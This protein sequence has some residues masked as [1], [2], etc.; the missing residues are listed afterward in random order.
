M[1]PRCYVYIIIFYYYRQ[2]STSQQ[3]VTS[4][5]I[6]DSTSINRSTQICQK[7]DAN[8]IARPGI[9]S[10]LAY[11]DFQDFVTRSLAFADKSELIHTLMENHTTGNF[12]VITSPP[13]WGKSINLSM[14]KYF[15]GIPLETYYSRTI[16]I[17]NSFTYNYFKN[18]IVKSKESIPDTEISPKPLISKY[19]ETITKYLG[20]FP[21]IQFIPP[22]ISG[23][24]T[25]GDLQFHIKN[26]YSDF[27]NLKK[28]YFPNHISDEERVQLLQEFERYRRTGKPVKYSLSFLAKLVS[29]YYNARV[30]VLVDGYDMVSNAYH[31]KN[32]SSSSTKQILDALKTMYAQLASKENDFVEL[33]VLTGV[34]RV[35]NS[36]GVSGMDH[37]Y[38]FSHLS[39]HNL[40]PYYGI[41]RD[42]FNELARLRGLDK[43]LINT[44]VNWYDGYEVTGY[45][46]VTY[47]SAYSIARFINTKKVDNYWTN[48]GFSCNF[49][50]LLEY[51]VFLDEI[52]QLL[53]STNSNF[54]PVPL[55]HIDELNPT[56]MAKFHDLLQHPEVHVYEQEHRKIAIGVLTAIGYFTINSATPTTNLK[57]PNREIESVFELQ[58]ISHNE[59]VTEKMIPDYSQMV[60]YLRKNFVS[61]FETPNKRLLD[62]LTRSIC[63]LIQHCG[64]FETLSE[65]LQQI[66][67]L[68]DFHDKTTS[69]AALRQ[70]MSPVFEHLK[71]RQKHIPLTELDSRKGNRPDLVFIASGKL[72]I[73]D[74]KYTGTERET[75][76]EALKKAF[77]YI[78]LLNRMSQ[79]T[80]TQ[81]QSISIILI[82]VSSMHV[83]TRLFQKNE[84]DYQMLRREFNESWNKP[85]HLEKHMR[86]SNLIESVMRY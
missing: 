25:V 14:L 35:D 73:V 83:E 34:M 48:S 45:P 53:K 80:K 3:T 18:G 71:C 62:D 47:F 21:I 11:A 84:N 81:I 61:V 16:D 67:I 32:A 82:R 24:S 50:G 13:R 85:V 46:G 57:L 8:F 77:R 52:S 42:E 33:A 51:K 28:A 12:Y 64:D 70:V 31:F 79:A 23:H 15:F 10:D 9:I 40:Y 41:T 86:Q 72:T 17:I 37:A 60:S 6:L 74:F 78:L 44:A 27:S 69:E 63:K 58:I 75:T 38:E 29:K 54:I 19:P 2:T 65:K 49:F 1:K 5:K 20:R 4:V 7:K 26:L 76:D 59:Q 39:E 22:T 36:S 56:I 30:V 68:Q 66:V 55:D 43:E